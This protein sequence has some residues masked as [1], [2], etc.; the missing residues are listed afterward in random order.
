M[1]CDH[2]DLVPLV[3]ILSLVFVIAL[4]MTLLRKQLVEMRFIWRDLGRIVKVLIDTMQIIASMPEVLGGIEWPDELLVVFSYMDLSSLDISQFLG[5]SCFGQREATYYAR[6]GMLLSL[7]VLVFLTA[8]AAFKIGRWST[9]R[10]WR[11]V[12]TDKEK[13]EFVRASMFEVFE[14]ADIDD[15]GHL[16]CREAKEV[17]RLIGNK[18]IEKELVLAMHKI[19]GVKSVEENTKDK[20]GGRQESKEEQKDEIEEEEEGK[21][22]NQDAL[23]TDLKGGSKDDIFMHCHEFVD[24][25]AKMDNIGPIALQAA[26]KNRLRE[27]LTLFTPF[28]LILHT[29][30][31][32]RIF[33]L[34]ACDKIGGSGM[35]IRSTGVDIYEGGGSPN[36]AEWDIRLTRGFLPGDYKLPCMDFTQVTAFPEIVMFY[37][38][39]FLFLVI[40][41]IGF[42]MALIVY[43]WL[44]RKKF[45]TFAVYS[46]I[47]FLYE[48]FKRGHEF[49]DLHIL[50]Y[51]T[52]LCAFI[53]FLQP[54]PQ[55]QS[56]IALSISVVYLTWFAWSRPMRNTAVTKVCLYGFCST[57]F[58]YMSMNIFEETG[59]DAVDPSVKMFFVVLICIACIGLLVA[60]GLAMAINLRTA[61]LTFTTLRKKRME[62]GALDD[63]GR[64]DEG[65]KA[66]EK[67]WRGKNI[68]KRVFRKSTAVVPYSESDI[69]KMSPAV[70]EEELRRLMVMQKEITASVTKGNASPRP[71]ETTVPTSESRKSRSSPSKNPHKNAGMGG[72]ED[73][74][75]SMDAVQ[76]KD[77]GDVNRDEDV[78]EKEAEEV[79]EVVDLTKDGEDKTPEFESESGLDL[80]RQSVRV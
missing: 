64:D 48:R 63:K 6:S 40:V 21:E 75:N 70:M 50:I 44:R 36:A 35:M 72:K 67:Q 42:P 41:T 1:A 79:E 29:P 18:T 22:K 53:V 28:L 16:D 57:C 37:I 71:T 39:S 66:E 58:M 23:S 55:L 14:L 27:M 2:Q 68:R 80:A 13:Q 17:A 3:V 25:M 56:V 26:S 49:A 31:T 24:F 9:S 60:G 45:Y 32:A 73:I 15:N 38:A 61:H 78:V 5:I 43:M 4:I 77:N 8:A 19:R 59:G 10:W 34:F 20:D 69:S 54:W 7:L 76:S 33:E 65:P 46:E 12:A 11:L 62:E 30:V 47:G 51:K 52:L 74:V